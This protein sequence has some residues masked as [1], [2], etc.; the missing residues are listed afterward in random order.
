M[1]PRRR[2]LTELQVSKLPRKAKRYYMADPVQPG[3]VLRIPPQGAIGYSGVGWRGGKQVWKAVGTTAT[4]SLAEA[5]ALARDVVR[6]V[7][8]GL[9]LTATPLHS[10]GA[11]ADRWLELK[12]EAEG[13]RTAFERRRIIEKYLKPHLGHR[14]LADL[15]RSDITAMMDVLADR[16][17]KPMAD[18]VLRTLSAICH[19]HETRSDD[20]RSP[21]VRGM[22]RSSPTQRERVLGDDEIR[23]VWRLASGAG[24]YGAFLK[25]ALL[26]AQRRAVL[27]GMRWEQLDSDGVWHIPHAPRAKQNGG[28]LKLPQLALEIIYSQPHLVGDSRVFRRPNDA[29]IAR[30]QASTELPHWTIHDLRRTARSLMSRAGIQTEISELVVGHS[31]KGIQKVYDRHSYFEE[32]GA[33][34]AR[35]ATLVERILNPAA[36]V[37]TLGAVS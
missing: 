25:T 34:L 5:R 1:A 2:T 15:R 17:G 23:I 4:I 12:A 9:P 20:F 18:Q 6:K 22:R 24:A 33:A 21:I 32:K 8:G 13:Y 27:Q 29:T 28:D 16:H 37:I 35:L 11:I 31:I 26:T 36:N 3:L 19:W 10:M 30:F 7:Q 14:I